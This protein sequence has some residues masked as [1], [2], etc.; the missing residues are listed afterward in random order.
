M[1]WLP[2]KI[3]K[4]LETAKNTVENTHKALKRVGGKAYKKDTM[5]CLFL[6]WRG[7]GCECGSSLSTPSLVALLVGFNSLDLGARTSLRMF[8]IHLMPPERIGPSPE[9]FQDEHVYCIHGIYT[10]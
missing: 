7:E 1:F 5:F 9:G 3:K 10:L 6:F 4:G 8:E 2:F